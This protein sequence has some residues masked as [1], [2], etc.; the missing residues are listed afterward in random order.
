MDHTEGITSACRSSTFGVSADGLGNVYTSGVIY[1]GDTLNS[2]GVATWS[3]DAYV[4]KYRDAGPEPSFLPGDLNR[5]AHVNA[6]D[7]PAMLAALVDL[8]GY[9]TANRLTDA[10][11]LS[12]GDLDASGALTNSDINALIGLLRTGG[13]SLDTVPEPASIVLL[14]LAL[15]GLV[16][17]IN[18]RRSSESKCGR[19]LC[20]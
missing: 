3:T 17:A 11:L 7:I 9:K 10:D 12:I 19:S 13:G 8:N 18:R 2:L 16:F 15:P 4:A 5:D 6:A 14:A 20:Q 1:T